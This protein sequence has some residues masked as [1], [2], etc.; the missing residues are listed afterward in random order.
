MSKYKRLQGKE[1]HNI[2]NE[3]TLIKFVV[4]K[5]GHIKAYYRDKQ[6]N[7]LTH[8]LNNEEI[9]EVKKV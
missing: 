7:T 3:L 8:W 6:G 5:K 1:W 2:K 4:N 9:E